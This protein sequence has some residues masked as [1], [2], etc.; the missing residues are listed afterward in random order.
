MA[1]K[2][3]DREV[4][5]QRERPLSSDINTGWSYGDQSM[6]FVSDVIA[7]YRAGTL[8]DPSAL[9]PLTGFVNDGFRVV[10]SAPAGMS[11]VVSAGL[12]YKVDATDNE[13]DIGSGLTP[14]IL[15]LDDNQRMHPLP[16]SS[17][18]TIVVPAADA[19]NPRIDIVEVKLDRRL[20]D[21]TSRQI[22]DPA[23]GLFSAASVNKTLAFD[24]AG[25]TGVNT[26]GGNSTTGIAYKTGTPAG[27]PVAAAVSTGYVKIAEVLVD[28]GVASVAL[29]KIKDLRP[30]MWPH[31]CAPFSLTFN[32]TNAPACTGASGAL[33]PGIN[34]GLVPGATQGAGSAF[35]MVHDHTKVSLLCAQVWVAG[36]TVTMLP[37]TSTFFGKLNVL[38]NTVAGAVQTALGA[39]TPSVTVALGQPYHEIAYQVVEAANGGV[40]GNATGLPATFQLHISGVLYRHS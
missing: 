13:S 3:F 19:V 7:Q 25:R 17:A 22:L 16:L 10:A 14:G 21:P 9:T 26:T 1:D 24:L 15:G 30:P 29:N 31:A 34:V 6:R 32:M 23:T 12:G 28:A 11:V 20:E 38:Q 36:T 37:A 8:G 35:F 40:V 2:P 4:I 39:A 18:Q 27:A 33:P 5:N